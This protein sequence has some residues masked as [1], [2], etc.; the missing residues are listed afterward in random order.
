MAPALP[1]EIKIWKQ[2]PTPQQLWTPKCLK[3]Q[4]CVCCCHTET[5]ETRGNGRQDSVADVFCPVS[6]TGD[7]G[8]TIWVHTAVAQLKYV[9]VRMQVLR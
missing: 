6:S 7:A 9:G 5:S 4:K 3:G 2:R 8:Q 1:I